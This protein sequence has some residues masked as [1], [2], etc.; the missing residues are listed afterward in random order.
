MM[1]ANKVY[2]K[3]DIIRMKKDGVNKEWS[4][5]GESNYSIWLYKGGGDCR[6]LWYRRIY[7]QTGTKA[8]KDDRVITTTKARSDGFKPPVNEQPVPV[9]PKNM[10]NRGFVTKKMS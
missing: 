3:E 6:H 8:S 1:R 4:K 10:D 5:K 9:A 2:R 7:V